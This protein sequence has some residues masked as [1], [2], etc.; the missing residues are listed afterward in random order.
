[1]K[2]EKICKRQ[3]F[4]INLYT[5]YNKNLIGLQFSQNILHLSKLKARSHDIAF[6]RTFDLLLINSSKYLYIKEMHYIKK[7]ER[8]S[9]AQSTALH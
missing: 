3:L 8:K 1:M 2:S 4:S 5:S 6:S 7:L 9:I